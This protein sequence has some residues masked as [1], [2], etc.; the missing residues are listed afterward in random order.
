MWP[1][2]SYLVIIL[3]IKALRQFRGDLKGLVALIEVEVLISH[4]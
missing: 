1:Y 4:W 2:Y 3:A